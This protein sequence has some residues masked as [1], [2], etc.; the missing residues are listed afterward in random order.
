MPHRERLNSPG[1][2]TL[3]SSVGGA[4]AGSSV[5]HGRY[6]RRRTGNDVLRMD[7]GLRLHF[8]SAVMGGSSVKQAVCTV[9][10]WYQGEHSK[11]NF[12]KSQRVWSTPACRAVRGMLECFCGPG[13]HH[14]GAGNTLD[15]TYIG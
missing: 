12:L 3:V 1:L 9:T 8:D 15:A 5:L 7:N 13:Q 2:L 11:C 10:L 14:G 6:C 4:L